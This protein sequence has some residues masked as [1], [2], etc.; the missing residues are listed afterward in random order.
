MK[1]EK[2]EVTIDSP[3]VSEQHGPYGADEYNRAPSRASARWPAGVN[4]VKL[5]RKIDWSIIPILMAAYF[6]QFLDKVIYNVCKHISPVSEGRANTSAQM[7]VRERHG[8][9]KRLGDEE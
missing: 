3:S 7:V 9:A 5:V 8:Y 6:L 2:F 4:E 1:D